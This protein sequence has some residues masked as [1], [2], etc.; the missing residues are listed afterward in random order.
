MEHFIF[1]TG[2][3][4][5][6]EQELALNTTLCRKPSKKTAYS[7]ASWRFVTN[8]FSVWFYQLLSDTKLTK[9]IIQLV[10]IRDLAGDLTKIMQGS[11]DV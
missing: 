8:I 5:L 7:G 1:L 3:N 4:T 10:L 2:S 11:T 9:N 6:A